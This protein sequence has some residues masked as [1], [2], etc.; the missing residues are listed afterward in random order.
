MNVAP[1]TCA[2]SLSA[3]NMNQA[4]HLGFRISRALIDT[5]P[6]LGLKYHGAVDSAFTYRAPSSCTI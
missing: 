4:G 2:R 6:N 5:T 3:G 1:L